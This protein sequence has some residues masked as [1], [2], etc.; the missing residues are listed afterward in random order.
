[1]RSSLSVSNCA[2]AVPSVQVVSSLLHQE[3]TCCWRFLALLGEFSC[4]CQPQA[5][6]MLLADQPDDSMYGSCAK[7]LCSVVLIGNQN[8]P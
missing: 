7:I 3:D 2:A 6:V 8:Y 4:S 5:R 1:M